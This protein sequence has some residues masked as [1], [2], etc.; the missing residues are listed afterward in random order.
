MG[1]GMTLGIDECGVHPTFGTQFLHV[2]LV[3][4][5]LGLERETRSFQDQMTVLKDQGIA[6]V[7]CILR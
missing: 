4:L 6:T 5:Q 1:V 2:N 7:D 3:H